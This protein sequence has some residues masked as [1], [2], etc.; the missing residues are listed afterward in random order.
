MAAQIIRQITSQMGNIK[1]TGGSRLESIFGDVTSTFPLQ[2]PGE[3]RAVAYKAFEGV[4]SVYAADSSQQYLIADNRS[5]TDSML[6]DTQL[7]PHVN[8]TEVIEQLTDK[9]MIYPNMGAGNWDDDF[10]NYIENQNN[11]YYDDDE[12]DDDY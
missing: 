9:K 7:Y 10:S 11:P 8:S 6:Q 12:D 3:G 1:I 4:Y 5:P 2:N